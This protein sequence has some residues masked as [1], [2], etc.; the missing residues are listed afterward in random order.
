MFENLYSFSTS[1][2]P[3]HEWAKGETLAPGS[4]IRLQWCSLINHST[5]HS[6]S[7]STLSFPFTWGVRVG[8]LRTTHTHQPCT[9]AHMH[10]QR[11]LH[12]SGPIIT[13]LPANE[14]FTW[15]L[16]SCSVALFIHRVRIKRIRPVRGFSVFLMVPTNNQMSLRWTSAAALSPCPTGYTRIN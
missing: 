16:N 8:A 11:H 6:S 12:T 2:A 1:R 13:V 14:G 4:T 5:R 9:P 15:E 7:T 10:M 3:A